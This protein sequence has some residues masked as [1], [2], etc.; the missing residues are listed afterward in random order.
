MSTLIGKTVSVAMCTYNGAR[1]VEAQ[2]S[3][4]AGQTRP[5]DEL[6][7]C[8]DCSSDDTVDLIE[9]FSQR[10]RFPVRIFRNRTN[11]GPYRNFEQA[12]SRC[13]GDY[14]FFCDQDDVWLPHKIDRMLNKMIVSEKSLSANIPILLHCDLEI[15]DA[16]LN[17]IHDSFVRYFQF[18]NLE[19]DFQSI[20][21]G[22][23]V[24]GCASA[25]NRPLLEVMQ[26][27][28]E[29]QANWHRF[30]HDWW[31]AICA[32]S[33][34]KVLFIDEVL[35]RYRIHANNFAGK[36]EHRNVKA[37]PH[38]TKL[39]RSYK[40]I[41]EKNR[42]SILKLK[43]QIDIAKKTSEMLRS[44]ERLKFGRPDHRYIC[45]LANLNSGPAIA[46]IR[47]IWRTRLQGKGFT[48]NMRRAIRVLR[49]E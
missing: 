41:L 6:V 4:L 42:S 37:M 18:P 36:L 46:R 35:V 29:V 14:V 38:S 43:Q 20:I 13:R 10:A 25:V 47:A 28:P 30:G 2:L 31:A 27:F 9:S 11:V 22:N 19:P 39:S 49:L 15:V 45:N 26:P 21:F 1:Y 8:D 5:P 16:N 44:T 24:T 17:H 40:R 12:L 3:S 34:G 23:V 7:V 48:K 33:T 32:A